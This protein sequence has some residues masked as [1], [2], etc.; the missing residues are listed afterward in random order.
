MTL[1]LAPGLEAVTWTRCRAEILQDNG[2]LK[3]RQGVK[4]M[5]EAGGGGGGG[6]EERERG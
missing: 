1:P 3:G 4:E 5:S 2:L 6:G